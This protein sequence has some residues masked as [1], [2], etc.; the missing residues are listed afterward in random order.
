MLGRGLWGQFFSFSLKFSCIECV[1]EMAWTSSRQ[2]SC[3]YVSS[4]IYSNHL[5][6]TNAMAARQGQDKYSMV[7]TKSLRNNSSRK[8]SHLTGI[9][10]IFYYIVI[11]PK[12]LLLE[13]SRIICQSC[14]VFCVPCFKEE[15]HLFSRQ[16]EE[17]HNG[18]ENCHLLDLISCKDVISNHYPCSKLELNSI[19]FLPIALISRSFCQLNSHSS[20]V[21]ISTI[22]IPR[23]P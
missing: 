21:I 14:S 16:H 8:I 18:Y 15:I 7:P 10:E 23:S 5:H 13:P 19:S 17:N 4:L 1:E 9:E 6:R 20:F 3:K 22:S 11:F 2:W 12:K